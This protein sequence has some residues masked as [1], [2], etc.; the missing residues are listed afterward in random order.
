MVPRLF[1]HEAQMKGAYI[2]Y[3]EIHPNALGQIALN[4]GAHVSVTGLT[5][6]H[7]V[8]LEIF[9]TEVA[10]LLLFALPAEGTG[11]AREAPLNVA[12]I[13]PQ[14]TLS[15]LTLVAAHLGQ[16]ATRWAAQG[17]GIPG[18]KGFMACQIG[19]QVMEEWPG[20]LPAEPIERLG[21]GAGDLGQEAAF[22]L[23]AVPSVDEKCP[24]TVVG[25]LALEKGVHLTESPLGTGKRIADGCQKPLASREEERVLG[26]R[27]TDIRQ[28]TPIA[29]GRVKCLAFGRGSW[30]V[31][32][33]VAERVSPVHQASL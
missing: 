22:F 29:D 32:K 20:K 33:R 23:E 6:I 18:G 13:A 11:E 9:R 15:F 27:V 10:E 30:I 12:K 25:I 8:L 3:G 16:P 2:L 21:V 4:F 5:Y 19:S 14:E 17:P 1:G 31:F 24:Q 28:A 26:K 7:T